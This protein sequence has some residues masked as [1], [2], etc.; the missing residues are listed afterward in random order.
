VCRFLHHTALQHSTT[1]HYTAFM[2]LRVTAVD[3]T[4]MSCAR[5]RR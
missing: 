4:A 1:Q 3:A 5:L 2:S